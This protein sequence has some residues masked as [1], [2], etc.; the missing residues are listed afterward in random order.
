M[1]I[2]VEESVLKKYGISMQ[3][4]VA[5][6]VSYY[7]VDI[8]QCNKN[9]IAKGLAAKNLYLKEGIVIGS[10]AEELMANII[11]DSSE[12]QLH[13]DA[14][15]ENLATKMQELYPKGKKPGTSY[16][17]R[18]T[19]I[20][21]AKKL[22]TLSVKYGYKLEEER[23]LKAT[24]NYVNSFNGDYQRMRLLKYFILKNEVD[25]DGN[26]VTVTDL[27]SYIENEKDVD[28]LKEDWTSSLA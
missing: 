9:L 6:L 19:V 26:T 11:I 15:Y 14:F 24:E 18:G 7:D 25:S 13:D 22:K 17:W 23:V 5:L 2:N 28:S 4:F 20:E 16:M 12:K 3:E 21:I 1:K 8:A 27:M 10:K